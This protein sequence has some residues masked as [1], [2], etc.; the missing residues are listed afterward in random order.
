MLERFWKSFF[1]IVPSWV[2]LLQEPDCEPSS[3]SHHTA[4]NQIELQLQCSRFL[5][6]VLL[7]LVEPGARSLDVD[8]RKIWACAARQWALRP[9]RPSSTNGREGAR[10]G[11]CEGISPTRRCMRGIPSVPRNAP[12]TISAAYIAAAFRE[13]A[14]QRSREQARAPRRCRCA[15]CPGGRAQG[16]SLAP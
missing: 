7:D 15:C 2:P 16:R 13:G 11:P 6:S 8:S 9:L 1:V 12:H 5:W 4:P 14:R 10:A 3:Q